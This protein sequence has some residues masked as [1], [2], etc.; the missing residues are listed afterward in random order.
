MLVSLASD[1][2]L[3]SGPQGGMRRRMTRAV[4]WNTLGTAFNQG[5]TF[6]VN[7]IGRHA[8]VRV[9]LGFKDWDVIF[10]LFNHFERCDGLT[11]RFMSTQHF[12]EVGRRG[13]R[14]RTLA[15]RLHPLFDILDRY[16]NRDWL[17]R[18]NFVLRSRSNPT[19]VL[20]AKAVGEGR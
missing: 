7:I 3:A 19:S 9:Q 10:D 13:F 15:R 14:V 17:P 2:V 12:W 5:S 16:R 6:V 4:A 11:A 1:P 18:Y 20:S 8:Q